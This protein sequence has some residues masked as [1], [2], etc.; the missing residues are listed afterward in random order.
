M[1]ISGV[2]LI[3]MAFTPWN[4][5]FEYH[6]IFVKLAFGFLLSWT[7]L[8]II[9]ESVNPKIRHLMITNIVYCAILI[10]YVYTLLNGPKFGTLEDLEYQAVAQKLII[11][12]SVLNFA[13]QAKGIMHFLRIADFRRG[14]KKNFYV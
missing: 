8:F 12:I 10:W 4:A 9:L 11:Y 14:G 7:I 2:C 13:V 3:G 1:I 5:F 6:V